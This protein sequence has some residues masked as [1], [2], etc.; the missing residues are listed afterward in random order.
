MREANRYVDATQ[1]WALARDA[2]KHAELAHVLHNLAAAIGVIGGLVTPVLPATGATLRAWVGVETPTTWPIATDMH[3]LVASARIVKDPKPLFPRLDE[4]AQAAMFAKIVPQLAAPVAAPAPAGPA[5]ITFD[6]F[7]KIELRVGKVLEA[8]AVPKA[9][10][11]LHLQVDLG[12]SAPRSIVAG[13]AEK[14]A[15]ADL[16]GRKV[17]VVANLAPATIRGVRSEG[18]I[19]RRGRRGDPRT[20]RDRSRRSPRHASTIGPHE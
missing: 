17:I 9:K 18:M 20:F 16:V 3:R 14:Y 12:E 2:S 19:A 5:P 6:D 11:L 7:G 4:A 10:K 15:P 13:I 8:A 1:P